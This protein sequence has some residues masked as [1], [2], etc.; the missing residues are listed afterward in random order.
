MAQLQTRTGLGVF[1][2]LSGGLLIS[3][4]IP[5]I[6]LA[7]AEP[8]L[9][10]LARGLGLALVLGLVLIIAGKRI[11]APPNPFDDRQFVEIGILFGVSSIFFTLAVFNTST[12]N[13]VFILAFNPMLAAIFAWALIGE[14]PDL[15]TWG[16]IFFTII[17]VAIIVS[18]GLEGGTLKGD[19]YALIT[20]VFLALSIVRTRQSAKNMSLAPAMGGMVTGLFALPIALSN[21]SMPEQPAWLLVNV[22]VLVP[23]AGFTLSF[24]PRFIPA[25]QVA[26]FFLLETVLAPIWV[27]LIF[28]EIPS[29]KTLTGGLIVLISIAFHTAWN[30]RAKN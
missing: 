2:A 24:A 8:W 15:V 22:L 23:L 9:V 29:N 1:L 12:A 25:P 19:I 27:W 18:D 5:V 14:R 17:G 16:T 7:G 10:M 20:A 28:A 3:I 13:L 11:G 26:V 30:L 6:R 4:D 21:F